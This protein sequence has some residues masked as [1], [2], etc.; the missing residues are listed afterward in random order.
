LKLDPTECSCAGSPFAEVRSER[1]SEAAAV[2]GAPRA[3]SRHQR[4]WRGQR[5]P[6]EQL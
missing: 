5:H 2:R 4:R 6:R 1:P 3:W